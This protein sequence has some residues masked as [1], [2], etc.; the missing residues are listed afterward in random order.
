[1]SFRPAGRLWQNGNDC[2]RACVFDSGGIKRKYTTIFNIQPYALAGVKIGGF[3]GAKARGKERLYQ[4]IFVV[5][6]FLAE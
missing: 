3:G 1:M 4:L 5:G 6:V 2:P